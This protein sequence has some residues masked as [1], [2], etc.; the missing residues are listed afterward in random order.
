[1]K[2]RSTKK[3]TGH[4]QRKNKTLPLWLPVVDGAIVDVI[5]P[6][7][8]C[9]VEEL[10][11]GLQFLESWGLRPRLSDEIFGESLLHAQSDQERW[12]QFQK[13]LLAKD[14]SVI[15]CARGGYGSMK[16]LP[17]L[18]KM[19]RPQKPKLLVGLSDIT[20]LHVFL[21]QEWGWPTLHAPI[22]SRMGRG[23][24]PPSTHHEIH[25]ILFGQVSSVTFSIE[26]FN[27]RAH[28]IK[29]L[30]GEIFGG[31]WTTLMANVGTPFS[32]QSSGSSG[33]LSKGSASVS[34][35]AERGAGRILFL[36]DV[37]ERGYRLDRFWEQW[38]QAGFWKDIQAV[39][40]GD[41]TEG[42]EPNGTNTI[43][44]VLK[45]RASQFK[46]PVYRGLPTGHGIIQ[47][48]L[49]FGTPA[50]LIRDS[51]SSFLLKVETQCSV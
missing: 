29:K 25:Q 31:N 4:S 18:Q 19:K 24:L 10:K 2:G 6:A 12:F 1:M 20:S 41:F 27:P 32:L 28:E 40:F 50:E 9:S 5:A 46:K 34:R 44:E 14:S 21:N 30:Q 43:W 26:P 49:P 37:G 51:Q 22:L 17:K 42:D 38:E 39:I 45:T 33:G 47:R 48:P 7:S 13:A 35:K 8:K 16:L 23:D 15:W 3:K 36:E 11:K